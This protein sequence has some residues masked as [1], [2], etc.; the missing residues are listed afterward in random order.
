MSWLASL[1][2]NDVTAF[3]ND[4]GVPV[5]GSGGTDVQV[6][7]FANP[8]AHNH[9][10]R[11][12]SCS[13]NLESGLWNC[14]G[15]GSH[16]NA[17]QAA[18]AVGHSDRR[19]REL[20]RRHRLFLEKPGVQEKEKVPGERDLKRWAK[21]L[22][23][24]PKIMARLTE[25]KG[26]SPGAMRRLKLGWDGERVVF[27]VR[28]DKLKVCGVVRY[29]PGGDP[30]TLGVGKRN[31]F[32]APEQMAPRHLPLF[33]VE[34]EPAAVSMFSIGLRAVAVPGAGSWRHEW[35]G[36]LGGRPSLVVLMDCDAPGRLLGA[37]LRTLSWEGGARA[38]V[39]D[40]EPGR[41]D[42]LDVGDWVREAFA[43]NSS[44]ALRRAFLRL[45]E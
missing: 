29:L 43:E 11:N 6:S 30:K 24:S 27:P 23:D 3:Y 38:R 1:K 14:F 15:C 4:I 17:F 36:R 16:G 25:L 31:L 45:A 22:A 37:Q 21:A 42:G 12:K 32:P 18:V 2:A 8:D 40:L 19:A 39:V 26:W 34:G 10:D 41:S 44:F 5:T 33:V 28:N 20:A 7:C 35:G 9:E 13:I